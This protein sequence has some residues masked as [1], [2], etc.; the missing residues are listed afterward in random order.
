MS[1][2]KTLKIFDNVKDYLN[3]LCKA[4]DKKCDDFSSNTCYELIDE[5]TKDTSG[6]IDAEYLK[7]FEGFAM[8]LK[9]FDAPKGFI[10]EKNNLRNI[11][12]NT[13]VDK[14]FVANIVEK[15]KKSIPAINMDARK[16][17]D[18]T[19]TY[20]DS[21]KTVYESNKDK[22]SLYIYKLWENE[23]WENYTDNKTKFNEIKDD[24]VDGNLNPC[25]KR[26]LEAYF[27]IRADGEDIKIEEYIKA[28]KKSTVYT[29]L[30]LN[31]IVE[32][33]MA[34]ITDLLPKSLREAFNEYLKTYTSAFP[35][36]EL[37]GDKYILKYTDD[38]SSTNAEFKPNQLTMDKILEW[39]KKV[40][41]K[42][43]ERKKI[44]LLNEEKDYK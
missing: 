42:L 11:F 34:K 32:N 39:V 12:V 35:K 38:N 28:L 9:N 43:A 17:N 30:R 23:C 41:T 22:T 15:V 10:T 2:E 25:Q 26:I 27:N 3:I 8:T 20:N 18:A 29:N 21:L 36:F 33:N 40:Q 16:C 24:L 5:I 14:D 19:K 37:S 7:S 6:K 4:T 1:S 31:L 13:T 44:P